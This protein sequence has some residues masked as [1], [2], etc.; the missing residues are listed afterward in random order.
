MTLEY[1][2]RI[3]QGETFQVAVPVLDEQGNPA[4]VSGMTARGQIRAHPTSLAVLY[5][6]SQAAGNLAF[7]GNDVVLTVPAATSAA[8]TWQLARYSL[9]LTA[10]DG[11]ITRLVEGFVIL[12]PEVTR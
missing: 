2:L 4:S 6:W 11:D 7:D 3:N 1:P 10:S 12:S 9:E 5:E 8:W